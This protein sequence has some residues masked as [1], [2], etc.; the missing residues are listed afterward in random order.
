MALP[1]RP[2]LAVGPDDVLADADALRITRGRSAWSY[3]EC[4]GTRF[5]G[6]HFD[7]DRFSGVP[8][9][10]LGV[11]DAGHWGTVAGEKVSAVFGDAT[12]PAEP[13]VEVTV[14]WTRHAPGR[15]DVNLPA[16]LPARF[17]GT[18]QR[19]SLRVGR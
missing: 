8:C 13:S 15:F 10:E 5:D 16:E 7:A 14:R 1:G 2:P 18:V 4:Q 12:T 11:F 6:A 17:G 19:G 3:L 9:T